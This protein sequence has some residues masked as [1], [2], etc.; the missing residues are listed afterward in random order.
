MTL[1][2]IKLDWKLVVILFF[3]LFISLFVIFLFFLPMQNNSNQTPSNKVFPSP[4]TANKWSTYKGKDFEV[5]FPINWTY[6]RIPSNVSQVLFFKP[7]TSS[8]SDSDPSMTVEIYESNSENKEFIQK[9]EQLYTS[10]GYNRSQKNINNSAF[11]VFEGE[12]KIVNVETLQIYQETYY[13][14]SFG[15]KLFEIVYKY[16]SPSRNSQLEKEFSQILSRISFFP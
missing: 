12:Y 16:K 3:I 7:R 11:T 13:T 10:L 15:N 9:K 14:G 1:Q 6:E 2:D 8:Q 4:T 5:Q